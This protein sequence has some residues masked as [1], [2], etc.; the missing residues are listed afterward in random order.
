MQ[1]NILDIDTGPT[2]EQSGTLT[3]EM[4]FEQLV[5]IIMGVIIAGYKGY[6]YYNSLRLASYINKPYNYLEFSTNEKAMSWFF[7]ESKYEQNP[8]VVLIKKLVN[9]DLDKS[10]LDDALITKYLKDIKSATLFNQEYLL[11]NSGENIV[12]GGDGWLNVKSNRYKQFSKGMSYLAT[13]QKNNKVNSKID[14]FRA[15][16]PTA[17]FI[18]TNVVKDQTLKDN[19]N[20]FIK[21]YLDVLTYL[22]SSFTIT[23]VTNITLTNESAVSVLTIENSLSTLQYD[24]K[25]VHQYAGIL[26]TEDAIYINRLKPFFIDGVEKIIGTMSDLKDKLFMKSDVFKDKI[27]DLNKYSASNKNIKNL[28]FST[29]S[30][31]LLP[32]MLGTNVDY[33]KASQQLLKFPSY[34]NGLNDTIQDFIHNLEQMMNE[35]SMD[36]LTLRKHDDRYFNI[37]EAKSETS[38]LIQVLV[39]TKANSDQMKLEYLLPNFVSLDTIRDNFITVCKELNSIDI[40]KLEVNVDTLVKTIGTWQRVLKDQD[41]TRHSA[42]MVDDIKN[43]T[44][45]IAELVTNIGMLITLTFQYITFYNRMVVV[46]ADKTTSN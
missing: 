35:H 43:N 20:E 25:M 42:Y 10:K 29:Y 7:G 18:L 2:N 5:P 38:G 34:I 28:K 44:V 32:V 36:R 41:D 9:P 16:K 33:L 14:F 19:V 17:D 6:K 30:D 3:T 31:M 1:K 40:T 26:T 8:T 23:K 11:K 4:A 13:M 39:N 45:H 12:F 22:S 15:H 24:I 21:S 46:L 37:L 27:N